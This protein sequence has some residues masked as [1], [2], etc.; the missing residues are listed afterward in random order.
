[1]FAEGVS[2]ILECY[3]IAIYDGTKQKT[4]RKHLIPLNIIKFDQIFR[5]L[6]KDQFH[7]LY[8]EN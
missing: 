2:L 3:I 7:T 1:M 5:K 4:S 6:F 8:D